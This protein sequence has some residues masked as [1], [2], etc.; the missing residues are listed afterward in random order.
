[1][2]RQRPAIRPYIHVSA[3]QGQPGGNLCVPGRN[4][5]LLGNNLL[6]EISQIRVGKAGY[7]FLCEQDRAV[8]IHPDRKRILEKVPAGVDGLFDRAMAGFDGSGKT[9]L[10]REVILGLQIAHPE[11]QVECRVAPGLAACG[12]R[13][14]LKGVL[15]NLLGNA[16]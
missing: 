15:E 16:R 2:S 3:P 11:R 9:G 10:A 6:E 1:M 8:I 14:M 12:D 13:N 7:L 4:I 5:D